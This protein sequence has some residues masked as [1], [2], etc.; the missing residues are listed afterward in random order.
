M[1]IQ[2]RKILMI[3]MVCT[4]LGLSACQGDVSADQASSASAQTVVQ[5]TQVVLESKAATEVVPAATLEALQLVFGTLKLQGTEQALTSAQ[6]AVLLPLWTN[7]QTLT[8]EMNPG[9]DRGQDPAQ[10]EATPSAPQ[11]NTELQTQIDDLL[12]QIQAAMTTEQIGAI[13][14]LQITQ[15]SAQTLME[16][17]GITL[18]TPAQGADGSQPQDGAPGGGQ[19]GTPPEGGTP[20]DGAAPPDGGGGGGQAPVDGATP[21]ADSGTR[22]AG[23]RVSSEAVTA[24]IEYLTTLNSGA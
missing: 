5:P 8:A 6:A 10:T 4:L 20:P 22:P 7:Y 19:G 16:E 2:I 17:L 1:K 3:V 18:E 12:T 14:A 13:E 9:Q 11:Q 24:L 23:S 15:E 21:P